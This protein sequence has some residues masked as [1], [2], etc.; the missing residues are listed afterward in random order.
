MATL[1]T[2]LPSANALV[3]FEA[4]GRHGSFTR[5]AEE[6]AMTQAAVSYAIRTLEERL[7]VKLFTRRHRSVALTEAGRRFH[8]DVAMGLGY[9]RRSAEDLT[10]TARERHVTLSASTAFASFWMLPRLRRL[11]ADLPD[12]DL[13]IQTG[14]HDVDIV[15]EG[16]P[17]A[18]RCGTSGSWAGCRDAVLAHEEI[19]AVVS[20]A[21]VEQQG[22]PED[23]AA[24][25]GHRLIHL[26]EPYRPCPDWG[27]WLRSLGLP[28]PSR[29]TGLL[30]NDYVLVVQAV[31]GGQGIGLGWKH[32]VDPM[33]TDG[34]LLYASRHVLR[35]A[36]AFHVVWPAE[37]A[38]SDAAVQ[39][40]EWMLSGVP[41]SPPADAAPPQ[42]RAD[43]PRG[44]Q[45]SSRTGRGR[46]T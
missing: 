16:M 7:G 36:H 22:M 34:L 21:Y 38:L 23:D 30:I 3:V 14:D 28:P 12:V 26:E 46:P 6:L 1:R 19:A 4:A 35:T 25:A 20:P 17:L 45:P 29:A 9:I 27:A 40:R 44:R 37:R 2:L 33:V 31:L 5:A 42:D 15:T 43:A 18:I 24:I 39:V 13:R 10:A 41:A 8:A 32:L 11:R